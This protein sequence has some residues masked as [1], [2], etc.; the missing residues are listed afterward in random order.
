MRFSHETIQKA[1][2]LKIIIVKQ[3][4]KCIE[5]PLPEVARGE[6]EEYLEG[7]EILQLGDDLVSH[8]LPI[9]GGP[10][11][12]LK[13]GARI[14]QLID[15]VSATSDTSFAPQSSEICVRS[16]P[17]CLHNRHGGEEK[18]WR[19]GKPVIDIEQSLLEIVLLG[20]LNFPLVTQTK[21]SIR[22]ERWPRFDIKILL[23]QEVDRFLALP[24]SKVQ[25]GDLVALAVKE[26]IR[27]AVD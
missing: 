26:N 23:I 7:A 9:L 17:L 2:F 24:G 20:Q 4:H 21:L 14:L 12:L 18:V 1:I 25:I 13:N 27:M 22:Q 5:S 15:S 16:K 19:L 11:D 8:S 6:G 10:W 3:L